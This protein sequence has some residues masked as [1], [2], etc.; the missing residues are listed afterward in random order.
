MNVLDFYT[1]APLLELGAEA[2]RMRVDRHPK[3]S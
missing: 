3:G 2:N 1:N